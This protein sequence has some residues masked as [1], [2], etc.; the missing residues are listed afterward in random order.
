MPWHVRDTDERLDPITSIPF[1]AVHL[2]ALVGV[3]LV[4][5]HWW[6]PVAA[7]RRLLRAHV[8]S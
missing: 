6:Y 2:A 3:F 5:L 8:R 4:G 7:H 1:F